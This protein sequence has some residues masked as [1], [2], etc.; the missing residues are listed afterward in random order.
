[1]SLS[2]VIQSMRLLRRLVAL[3]RS[4]PL[5]REDGYE[6]TGL[7][8]E[9]LLSHRRYALSKGISTLEGFQLHRGSTTASLLPRKDR[10]VGRVPVVGSLCS[11][12]TS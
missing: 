2:S 12:G 1:V 6:Q 11:T 8:N 9:Y 5:L 3:M 7:T 4:T 10:L